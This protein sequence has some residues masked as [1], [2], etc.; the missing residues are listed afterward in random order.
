MV[1]VASVTGNTVTLACG[2]KNDYTT[3]DKAQ[4]VRVPQY[5]TLTVQAGASSRRRLEWHGG[6]RRGRARTDRAL[7]RR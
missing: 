7:A 4:V 5:T 6:R 1:E 3:A 2:L